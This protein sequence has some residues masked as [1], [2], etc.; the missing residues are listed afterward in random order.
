MQGMDAL[1]GKPLS[2]EAHLRQS[3][4]D[5]L[6][7]RVGERVGRRDYGSLLPD[8]IDSAMN[9]AGRL[10]IYAATAIALARWEPR[11][12]ATRFELTPG[13][14]AGAWS[15]AIDGDRLDAP[16]PNTRTRVIVP[17]A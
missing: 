4:T 6:T 2:G 1:T 16:Q 15:L 8:L 11:I 5:I 3:I 12:R 9:A 17:L 14:H 13:A 10:R 7:T